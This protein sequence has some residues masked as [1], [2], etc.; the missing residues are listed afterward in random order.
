MLHRKEQVSTFQNL[1]RLRYAV[2]S[3]LAEQ[4]G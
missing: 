4:E 3:L 1:S 2:Q